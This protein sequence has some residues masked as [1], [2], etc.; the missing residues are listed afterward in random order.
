MLAQPPRQMTVRAGEVV[1][2]SPDVVH[3][4]NPRTARWSYRMFYFDAMWSRKILRDQTGLADFPEWRMPLPDRGAR[5][6]VEAMSAVF[7][8]A[9]LS[10]GEFARHVGEIL[11][12]AAIVPEKAFS[13]G[14]PVL[15]RVRAHLDANL[16]D[17]ISLA[18]LACLA[19]MSSFALLRAFR[20]AYGLTPHAYQIDRR[21][22]HARELLR[23]GV[24]S[25]DA[26]YRV[27]FADQSHLHRCFRARVAATPGD[28]AR[29]R[30]PA[31]SSKK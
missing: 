8:G 10:A 27:G 6:A 30:A 16:A 15:E 31:I 17:S 13:G 19:G 4:C 12:R 25:A 2:F 24:P 21:I 3:S 26:A 14:S 1:I 20:R 23:A 22:N 29:A 9:E 28:Y 5:A 18:Q 7:A 11:R